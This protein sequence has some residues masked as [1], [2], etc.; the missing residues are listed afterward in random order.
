MRPLYDLSWEEFCGPDPF[1]ESTENPN[2]PVL[3]LIA[4][5]EGT[6]TWKCWQQRAL[7][8]PIREYTLWADPARGENEAGIFLTAG[9]HVAGLYEYAPDPHTPG[10]FVGPT[11]T[12]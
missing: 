6:K 10:A 9:D 11:P 3:D 2:D 12:I 5:W 7:V 4:I 8:I 1:I